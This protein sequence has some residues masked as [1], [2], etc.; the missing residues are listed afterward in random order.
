MTGFLNDDERLFKV[1]RPFHLR[2]KAGDG[3][4]TSVGEK[5]IGEATD[6]VY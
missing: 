5:D 3:H 1:L 2:T 4:V 6:N